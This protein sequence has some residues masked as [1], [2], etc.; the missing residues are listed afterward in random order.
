MSGASLPDTSAASGEK[1][2]LNRIKQY[3][4]QHLG[5]DSLAQD[6]EHVLRLA[7]GAL[8]L[9][10]THMD[11]EVWP[12]QRE[13]V[14]QAVRG[15]FDLPEDE[16]NA[17][18]DLAE[19]ERSESSDY[20]QFTSLINRAYAPEQKARLVETLWRVAYANQALHKYEEH[21]VRKVADLLYVPHSAFIAAKHRARGETALPKPS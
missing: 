9:E 15:C 11:G 7:I 21:L 2:M 16:A 18:L 4:D 19:A 12:E 10:M 5:A 20:F 14:E 8:L 6:P 13:A 3:F 1:G 17:L